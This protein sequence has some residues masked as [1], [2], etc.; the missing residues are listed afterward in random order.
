MRN[1]PTSLDLIFIRSDGTIANIEASAKPFSLELIRSKGSVIAVLEV[2]AG[3]AKQLGI[4]AGDRVCHADLPPC[5][6]ASF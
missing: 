6:N 3:K 5:Q 1:T 4:S 2:G